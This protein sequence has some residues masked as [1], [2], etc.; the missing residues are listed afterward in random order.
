MRTTRTALELEHRRRDAVNRVL[1]GHTQTQVAEI[2]NVD[3][4]TVVRWMQAYRAGGD[5]ALKA[6]PRPGPPPKLAAEQTATV[7]GWL[8]Q[9]PSAFGFSTELWTARRIAHLIR[10]EFGVTMNH[11]YLNAWLTRRGITPQKPKKQARERD[12]LRID[13]WLVE[14]WSRILKKGRPRMPISC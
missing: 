7:L 1:A 11:R 10:Q 13:R 3:R 12:P 6:K 9:K 2:F 8:R 5:A 14:D 4:R